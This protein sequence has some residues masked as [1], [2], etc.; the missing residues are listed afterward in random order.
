M[1]PTPG[2]QRGAAHPTSRSAPGQDG[3]GRGRLGARHGGPRFRTSG[4]AHW[5]RMGEALRFVRAGPVPEW[6]LGVQGSLPV[7]GHPPRLYTY[8]GPPT[9]THES[10]P[11]EEVGDTCAPSLS[12]HPRQ[13]PV[14][15]GQLQ[16]GTHPTSPPNEA[17]NE[18]GSL[19]SGGAVL[20]LWWLGQ[21]PSPPPAP[22]PPESQL[23]LCAATALRAGHALE[24]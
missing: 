20:P 16:H 13:L 24:G 21:P 22:S 5:P 18:G 12:Q 8:L 15:Q 19:I 7:P 10:A 2:E 11:A 4:W 3:A 6:G 17:A 14:T 9:A 23:L 1:P